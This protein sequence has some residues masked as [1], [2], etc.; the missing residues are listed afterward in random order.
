MLLLYEKGAVEE[1]MSF[2]R[3]GNGG[4]AG[5][6]EGKT[7][8]WN[9]Y[10]LLGFCWLGLMGAC[11]VVFFWVG[12]LVCFWLFCRKGRQRPWWKWPWVAVKLCYLVSCERVGVFDPLAAHPG[13]KATDL[14][15]LPSFNSIRPVERLRSLP[16]PHS[17]PFLRRVLE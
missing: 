4:R 6:L 1:I 10:F 5:V 16:P 2:F 11:G 14:S 9:R 13:V 15:G 17:R 12:W 8:S 3:R 7:G